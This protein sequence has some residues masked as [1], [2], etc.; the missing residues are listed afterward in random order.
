[1]LISGV[2]SGIGLALAKEYLSRG[3]EVYG[4][5]RRLCPL[6]HNNLKMSQIDLK[7]LETL[8]GDL[9][10]LLSEVNQLDLVVLNAGLLGKIAKMSDVSIDE[11]QEIM[12]V[13]MWANKVILDFL[14][15]GIARVDQVIG[16]SS[17]AAVNGNKGWGAYS[18]SKCAL[19]M[20]LKLYAG[21]QERTHFTA[22]AAGLVDTSMQ[23]Y[24]CS[25]EVGEDF[26]SLTRIQASRGTENM[27]TPEALA[28]RLPEVFEGLKSRPSGD[29]VD[30]RKM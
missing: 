5:S 3:V 10:K 26:P 27:P 21:E 29:F 9:S 16:V 2:S 15:E 7:N 24:L 6:K 18:L 22:F 4:F 8:P 30:L 11:M 13:N 25:L 14:F 28:K 12:A 1:M 23:D 20:L 17:G 19:N